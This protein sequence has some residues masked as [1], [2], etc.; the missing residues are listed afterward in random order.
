MVSQ[1]T[2]LRVCR[3]CVQAL[4][5]EVLPNPAGALITARRFVESCEVMPRS[6]GRSI[7][8]WHRGGTTLVARNWSCFPPSLEASTAGGP[9]T[10]PTKCGVVKG[11]FPLEALFVRRSGDRASEARLYDLEAWKK[12]QPVDECRH[13]PVQ[14]VSNPETLGAAL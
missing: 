2:A 6:R 14:F 8:P 4:A 5:S 10:E 11:A 3:T 13:R 12:W 1:A 9:L 7:S